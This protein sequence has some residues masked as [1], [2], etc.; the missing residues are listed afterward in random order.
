MPKMING[1]DLIKEF[2]RMKDMAQKVE[3]SEKFDE[4]KV[5]ISR[6]SVGAWDWAI[7][8]VRKLMDGDGA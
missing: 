1:E 3:A 6:S 7:K 4:L 5:L 2:E 8:A